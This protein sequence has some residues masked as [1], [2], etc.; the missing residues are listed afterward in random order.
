MVCD[1]YKLY[2]LGKIPEPEFKTH[3]EQCDA[4]REALALDHLLEEE[5]R[6]LPAPETAP[7]LWTRIEGELKDE[8]KKRRHASLS[9]IFIFIVS[10]TRYLAYKVAAVAL[11]G[12][13][14]SYFFL[15]RPSDMPREPR[16]LL[17][18]TALARIEALEREY[19]QAIIE[20]EKITLPIL[21]E[22]DSDL[23][24]LYRDRLETIDAQIARCK[25]AL[26]HNTADAHIQRYLLAA[27]QD[28]KETLIELLEIV[29]ESSSS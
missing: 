29:S 5:A 25:E 7:Y 20:L 9:D 6:K 1:R 4:C 15:F 24:L 28:K 23:L 13:G 10:P 17:T 22:A 21:A 19:E 26:E 8:I 3:L 12:I 2:A 14:L 18:S 16:H 27:Y 11:I